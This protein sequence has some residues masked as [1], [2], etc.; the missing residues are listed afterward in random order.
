[1]AKQNGQTLRIQ[2]GDGASPEL[3]T[4]IAG[5]IEESFSAEVGE[6]NVT[7]KDS[8]GYRE[9]LGGG[10]KSLNLSVSGVVDSSVLL[11]AYINNALESYRVIWN[12]TGDTLTGTFELGSYSQSGPTENGAITFTAEFRSSGA[13][14][15]E[16]GP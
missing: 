12:D 16:A 10:I 13:F 4:S 15:F 1:M 11:Q 14:T 9:L 5:A 2:K 3:F 7:D 8:N 6:I